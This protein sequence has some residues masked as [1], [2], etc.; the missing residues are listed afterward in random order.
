MKILFYAPELL[1]FLSPY[2]NFITARNFTVLL[3]DTVQK[4]IALVT[5]VD[6]HNYFDN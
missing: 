4:P 1:G 3:F 6:I 2:A 5:F